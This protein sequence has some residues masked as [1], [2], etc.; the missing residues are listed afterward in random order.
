[1]LVVCP[2]LCPFQRG[3]FNFA[4]RGLYYFALTPI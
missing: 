2:L 4:K 3:H 1:L